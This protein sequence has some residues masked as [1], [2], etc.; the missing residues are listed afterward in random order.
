MMGRWIGAEALLTTGGVWS[1]DYA[2]TDTKAGGYS[3]DDTGCA[4]NRMLVNAEDIDRNS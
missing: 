2:G 4:N 1:R 3:K